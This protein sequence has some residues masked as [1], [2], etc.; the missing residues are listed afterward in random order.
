MS[1]RKFALA[2]MIAVTAIAAM[3]ALS[4][5]ALAQCPPK[6]TND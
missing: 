1:T 4:T 2:V 5:G 3:P 6:C